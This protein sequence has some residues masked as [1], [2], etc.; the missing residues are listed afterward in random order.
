MDSQSALAKKIGAKFC[1]NSFFFKKN[2]LPDFE[3]EKI[4]Q[5]NIKNSPR[6]NADL[7][8]LI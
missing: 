4:I 8:S 5:H 6:K 7:D 2:T 3:K 1:Q